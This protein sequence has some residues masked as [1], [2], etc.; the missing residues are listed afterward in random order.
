M[1]TMKRTLIFLVLGLVFLVPLTIITIILGL[2]Y[3]ASKELILGVLFLLSWVSTM[4]LATALSTVLFVLLA[5]RLHINPTSPKV[6]AA[7]KTALLRDT[8]AGVR[9]KAAAGLADLDMEESSHYYEHKDID[10]ALI[11]ALKDEDPL[12]RSEV[13]EGLTELE[14]EPFTHLK[15]NQLEDA[16]LEDMA[17]TFKQK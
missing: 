11:S 5:L 10:N 14:L 9:S 13:A 16:L 17:R 4:V 8:N 6:L 12:V 2:E 1:Q 15:H 3:Y 7:L